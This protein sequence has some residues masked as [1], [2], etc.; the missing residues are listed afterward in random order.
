[1]KN[2]LSRIRGTI[3]AKNYK[4]MS[5]NVDLTV[6]DTRN[7]LLTVQHVYASSDIRSNMLGTL[8]IGMAIEFYI[9][10][11]FDP[12]K[13]FYTGIGV[14][15]ILD[16]LELSSD[17][18]DVNGDLFPTD[19]PPGESWDFVTA[20]VQ[21]I[22]ALLDQAKIKIQEEFSPTPEAM[23]DVERRLDR[24]ARKARET[25]AFDWKRLFVTAIV[26]VAADLGFG[27]T[28]P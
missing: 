26:G 28:V 24:L 5:T 16:P 20:D 23:Q 3:T 18:E 15:T 10:E 21:R 8:G 7:R 19:E 25:T 1:M 11:G 12:L 6:R 9:E 13:T 14:I 17:W 22:R 4:A 2:K 27:G